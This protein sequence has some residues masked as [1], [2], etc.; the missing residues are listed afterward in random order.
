MGKVKSTYY[1]EGA[2]DVIT[3]SKKSVVRSGVPN[4]LQLK[5]REKLKTYRKQ[6]VVYQ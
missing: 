1:P 3:E 4:A 5:I 6:K 2:P